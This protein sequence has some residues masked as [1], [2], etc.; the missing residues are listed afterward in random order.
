VCLLAHLELN[1]A[2]GGKMSY[3]CGE[4]LAPAR[5]RCWTQSSKE[6]PQAALERADLDFHF[7]SRKAPDRRP[8]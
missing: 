3:G 5:R 8:G 2:F 7:H 4:I 1:L 6:S